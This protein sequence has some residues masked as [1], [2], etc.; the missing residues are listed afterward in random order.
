MESMDW[1]LRHR[2]T[3]G[4]A[5]DRPISKDA[6]ACPLL[7]LW[8]FGVIIRW[9][10]LACQK[11][12]LQFARLNIIDRDLNNIFAKTLDS[13]ASVDQDAVSGMRI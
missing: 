2:L 11:L 7:Y 5:T 10:F 4:A 1:L 12:C 13:F 6:G 8:L 3:K 9:I